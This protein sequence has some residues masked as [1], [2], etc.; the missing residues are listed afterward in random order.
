MFKNW[1][2]IMSV[3]C[4][5]WVV[6]S[7]KAFPEEKV[8]D[9]RTV[10]FFELSADV[11][12]IEAYYTLLGFFFHKVHQTLTQEKSAV[13]NQIMHASIQKWLR[14]IDQEKQGIDPSKK[15]ALWVFVKQMLDLERW[16]SEQKALKKEGSLEAEINLLKWEKFK[17][18]VTS[19]R[20]YWSSSVSK[21]PLPSLQSGPL[22]GDYF[23]IDKAAIQK[24]LTD[25]KN[26]EHPL[27]KE[28]ALEFERFLVSLLSD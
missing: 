24:V 16:E 5:T 27:E 15:R 19:K 21:I 26:G 13:L 25:L 6:W 28:E 2:K 7:S 10:G 1:I 4:L 18:L 20:N 14:L 9:S 23:S 22:S 17:K 8:L 12:K 11:P 3:G